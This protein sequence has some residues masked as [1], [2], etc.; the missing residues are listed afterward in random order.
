M[1]GLGP[2]TSDR[3]HKRCAVLSQDM[4]LAVST[5]VVTDLKGRPLGVQKKT[6]YEDFG[7]GK[8]AWSAV[9]GCFWL[10]LLSN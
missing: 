1:P 7:L 3:P 2:D 4:G 8:H 10:F 5:I 9:S 6:L